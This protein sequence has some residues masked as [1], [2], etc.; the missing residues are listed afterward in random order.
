MTLRELLEVIDLDYEVKN[1]KIRLVDK[2]D[3]DFGNIAEDR[4]VAEQA[5][6]LDI[7]ERLNIYWNDYV[8]NAIVDPNLNLN[9]KE[10]EGYEDN[11]SYEELLD[12]CKEHEV[13]DPMVTVLY[14]LVNPN[15]VV[16]KEGVFHH[17]ET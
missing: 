11:G 2:T 3:V 10:L 16:L 12:Y 5:S 6:V 4:W 7:I 15:E 8:Y 1:G 14:Y 17:V 13:K 9:G